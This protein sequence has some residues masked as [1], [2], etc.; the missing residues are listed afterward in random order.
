[1]S[2]LVSRANVLHRPTLTSD[3][4]LINGNL[5]EPVTAQNSNSKNYR[6]F[7]KINKI[8]QISL[9]QAKLPID[10]NPPVT[11]KKSRKDKSRLKSQ[12]GSNLGKVVKKAGRN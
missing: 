5:D 3:Y 10:P 2:K 9:T 8:M 1:M 7:A 6:N 4:R 11:P 12:T